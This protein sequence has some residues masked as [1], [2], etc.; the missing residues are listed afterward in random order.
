MKFYKK[1]EH[2]LNLLIKPVY[3]NWS[4][5]LFIYLSNIL[6]A[7]LRQS[8]GLGQGVYSAFLYAIF[9]CYLFCVLVSWGKRYALYAAYTF[10][11]LLFLFEFVLIFLYKTPI[12]PFIL[13]MITQT[14]A[15]E[16]KEFLHIFLTTAETRTALLYS[17]GFILTFVLLTKVAIPKGIDFVK[18]KYGH[19]INGRYLRN[20]SSIALLFIFINSAYHE[21]PQF[22]KITNVFLAESTLETQQPHCRQPILASTWTRFFHAIAFLH[23]QSKDMSVLEK[24]VSQTT[25]DEC[26]FKSPL[27]LLIIGES[28]N[29]YHTPLYN[30]EAPPTTPL[31]CS[32][33]EK[34][35]LVP[36]TDV[37][38]LSNSTAVVL[39]QLF[40]TSHPNLEQNWTEFTLFP[41]VFKKAGYDVH[42]YSNQYIRENDTSE[43]EKAGGAIFN[44]GK[45]EELQ[46]TTRNTVRYYYDENLATEIDPQKLSDGK[47]KLIILHMLGQHF[48]Y[49]ERYPED[50]KH[51]TKEDMN[52]KYGG[53]KGREMAMHYAN[54]TYYNDYVVNYLLDLI[55][56]KESIAIYLADHGEEIYDHRDFMLRSH[57]EVIPKEVAKYQYEVPFMI[58]TSPSYKEKHGDI[59]AEIQAAKDKPFTSADL[60]QILLYLAG[61]KCDAYDERRNPL[62]PKFNNTKRMLRG[63]TDYDALIR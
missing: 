38:T 24:T 34:N 55:S 35:E 17:A 36:F 10:F 18:R 16:S 22:I 21:I 31:L 51:F 39:K 40:S 42:F 28:Y 8:L 53:D 58:Y 54:A 27:I 14:N 3:N 37:V 47:P 50:F 63:D 26:S 30:P 13:E 1:A 60:S 19:K 23:T 20:G 56:D 44:Y 15:R 59:V 32:R 45:L 41:A 25:V 46:F 48:D 2:F 29:K 11:S 62:S 49:I 4:F 33:V 43:F 5:F 57:E 52:T 61:I 6:L 12:R 7:Y 9:D